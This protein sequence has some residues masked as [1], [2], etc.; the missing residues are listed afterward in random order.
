MLDGRY[1]HIYLDYYHEKHAVCMAPQGD[2]GFDFG[3]HCWIFWKCSSPI[4]DPWGWYIYLHEHHKIQ[5]NEGI[6]TLGLPPTQ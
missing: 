2:D 1:C 4:T 5:Q 3:F 6:Y